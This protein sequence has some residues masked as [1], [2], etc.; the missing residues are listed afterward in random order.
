MYLGGTPGK[1]LYASDAPADAHEGPGEDEVVGEHFRHF[2]FEG[3]REDGGDSFTDLRRLFRLNFDW[4][5]IRL[6]L[7]H[8]KRDTFMT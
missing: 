5:V 2:Y 4:D 7:N 3:L 1:G 8:I 6:R